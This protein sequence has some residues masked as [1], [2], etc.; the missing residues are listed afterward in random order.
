MKVEFV[1]RKLIKPRQCLVSV[2]LHGDEELAALAAN[3]DLYIEA[4][5]DTPMSAKQM[6]RAW[7]LAGL[8]AEQDRWG[9]F[10]GPPH[11]AKRQ[12]MDYFMTLCRFAEMRISPVTGSGIVHVRSIRD[13]KMDEGSELIARAQ[14]TIMDEIG[15]SNPELIR[16]MMEAL[17]E[18]D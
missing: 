5:D 1:G 3:K 6:R 10:P 16:Q 17:G 14:Q 7:W 11:T 12:A 18:A 9:R 15:I 4:R 13:L 8:L 2:D